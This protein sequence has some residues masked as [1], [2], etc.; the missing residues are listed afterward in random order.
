MAC[1]RLSQ[2]NCRCLLLSWLIVSCCSTVNTATLALSY[3]LHLANLASLCSGV[4]ADLYD[5]S[6][7]FLHLS[8]SSLSIYK[9]LTARWLNSLS[10]NHAGVFF[11]WWTYAP[12]LYRVPVN[13]SGKSLCDECTYQPYM[14]FQ[15]INVVFLH[16]MNACTSFIL[17]ACKLT[18]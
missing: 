10:V 7:S 13:Y 9:E 16:V 4:S 17:S 14:E 15:K 2:F 18:L 11:V 5:L 8:H 12:A 3:Y 1:G 6:R